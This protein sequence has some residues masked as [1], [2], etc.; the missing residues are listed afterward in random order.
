M[1][2]NIS[3]DHL[4]ET[5]NYTESLNNLVD[6]QPG[7]SFASFVT[8]QLPLHVASI[9]ITNYT[10][11][12]AVSTVYVLRI[13]REQLELAEVSKTAQNRI[14]FS[15]ESESISLNG[16]TMGNLYLSAFKKRLD[17]IISDL[18]LK[19]SHIFEDIH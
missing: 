6:E 16:N 4:Q 13:D 18:T 7:F 8:S 11:R 9:F 15:F 14:V 19:K 1:L 5:Q 12:D 2:D 10:F 17:Q 3:F